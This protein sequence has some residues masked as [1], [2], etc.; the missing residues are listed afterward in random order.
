MRTR[1]HEASG[2]KPCSEPMAT[3]RPRVEDVLDQL[4]PP[5]AAARGWRGRSGRSPRRR[6]PR[7]SARSPRRRRGRLAAGA[8]PGR[9]C[10]AGRTTASRRRRPVSARVPGSA[11]VRPRRW[12]ARR[13]AAA[14]RTV[15]VDL[16]D[17]L[18]GLLL[19]GPVG[20]DH[21]QERQAG[22]RPTNCTERM[23]ADSWRGPDHHR[24]AVG[25]VGQEARGA[26]RASARCRHG[27][28]RRTAGPAGAAPGPG[29]RGRPGG[30]RRSGSPCRWG[31]GRRWCGAGPGSRRA[32][33]PPCRCA[34][35]PRRPPPRGRRSC[36]PTTGWAVRCTRRPPP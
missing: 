32:R 2:S 8:R 16:V 14:D 20:Q 35:W 12:A 15:V 30:R 22:P 28:G 10:R 4:P 17:A 7:P 26:A 24:R 33:G 18:D 19:D 23:A 5:P 27:R 29:I 13:A 34:R 11:R 31:C 25:E 3:E 1:A 36:G 6:R 21:H 9:G